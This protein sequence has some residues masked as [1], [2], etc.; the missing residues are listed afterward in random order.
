MS[1]DRAIATVT[2]IL[3]ARIRSVL[4]ANGMGGFVSAIVPPSDGANPGAYLHL[5]RVVPNPALQVLD[6]PTRRADGSLARRP[7]LALSLHYQ[8]SFMA[9][10]DNGDLGAERMAGLVLAEFH[11][12]PGLPPG[13]IAAFIAGRP[14]GDPLRDSDLDQQEHGVRVSMLAMDL[15]SHSRLWSM[16]NQSFHSLTVAL[17]VASVLIEDIVEPTVSLPVVHPQV[18]TL[19]SS[20]PMLEAAVSSANEQPLVQL[21]PAASPLTE[22][23][24]LRGSNLSGPQTVVRI[25]DVELFPTADEL[26]DSEIRI[27]LD[28]GSGLRPGVV[29]V[30]VEH[31]V[32]VDP[33]PLTESWRKGGASGTIAIA[34]VP[35]STIGAVATDGADRLVTIAMVPN[36]SADEAMMLLLD[37]TAAEGHFRGEV[38]PGSI[39]G[40]DVQFR[41]QGLVAGTYRVRVVVEGA[42]SLLTADASGITGPEVIVP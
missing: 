29:G 35:T 6:L 12:R 22:S 10:A 23:L 39:A 33:D 16:H 2:G 31:R 19:P 25:G 42:T 30:Q 34:L 15:E 36:P 41:V 17:E 26:T 21:Y 38:E 9:S 40:A 37:G 11:A 20:T 14:P 32:D 3:Q 7:Q 27:A 28:D 13:E 1:N 5:F 8:L 24:V 18:T 4:S